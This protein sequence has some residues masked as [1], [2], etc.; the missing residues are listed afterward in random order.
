MPKRSPTADTKAALAGLD[1][2][3]TQRLQALVERIERLEE[4]RKALVDDPVRGK[5]RRLGRGGIARTASPSLSLVL[6][7][8]RLRRVFNV[9][10]ATARYTGARW[11]SVDRHS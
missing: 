7:N 8:L 9:A 5:P 1:P 3:A 2:E 10:S 4:E 6:S 11:K